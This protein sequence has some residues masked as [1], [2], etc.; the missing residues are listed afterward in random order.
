[1]SILK[2]KKVL[3]PIQGFILS[4]GSPLGWMTIQVLSGIDPIDD[5]MTNTGIYIYTAIGTALAFSIF[6][7]YVG[8]SEEKIEKGS[9]HEFA[10]ATASIGITEYIKGD[11]LETMIKRAD[12]ALYDAKATGRNRVST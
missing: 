8:S 4:V 3:R 2:H 11:S 1:M 6:G 12:D 10:N 5:M 9:Y 7:Y